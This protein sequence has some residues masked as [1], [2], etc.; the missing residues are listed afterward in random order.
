[1]GIR[2]G[3]GSILDGKGKRKMA[4]PTVDECHISVICLTRLA[5]QGGEKA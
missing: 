2:R 4:F 1:M 3:I 5:Q